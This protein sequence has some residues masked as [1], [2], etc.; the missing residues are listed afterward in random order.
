MNNQEIMNYVEELN[1]VIKEFKKSKKELSAKIPGI[2]QALDKAIKELELM[3]DDFKGM[4]RVVVFGHSGAGK[5]SFINHLSGKEVAKVEHIIPGTRFLQEYEIE[6]SYTICDTRG[7]KELYNDKE[8]QQQLMNDIKSSRPHLFVIIIDGSRRDN[9]D[10]EIKLVEKIIL[11]SEKHF[12]RDTKIVIL[13]NRTDGISPSGLDRMPSIPWQNCE[14]EKAQKIH[15]RIKWL[16]E[17]LK[18]TP[19]LLGVDIIPCVLSWSQ[20]AKD[21]NT[22]NIDEVKD[23]IFRNSSIALLFAFSSTKESDLVEQKLD[24]IAFKLM[25]KFVTVAGIIGAVPIPIAD[26]AVLTTLQGLLVKAISMIGTKGTIPID[27]FIATV[28]GPAGLAGREAFRQFIKII[29]GFGSAIAGGVAAS[30]TL[31]I[32]YL[33]I[34]HYIHGKHEEIIKKVDLLAK[35]KDLSKGLGKESQNDRK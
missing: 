25:Y 1:N 12:Q 4:P 2:S 29:P 34:Q 28:V 9:I 11:D 13:L 31:G 32:G 17:I 19:R 8:S 33:A 21:S 16:N 22:W 10:T 30:F 15:L 6:N 7:L 26:I 14:S 23:V 24:N 27:D 20:N 35:I 5:S 3:S 18:N